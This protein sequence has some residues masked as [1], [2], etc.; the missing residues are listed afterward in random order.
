MLEGVKA[1][2]PGLL[3]NLIATRKCLIHA[4]VRA[5]GLQRKTMVGGCKKLR[6][7][8]ATRR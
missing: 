3:P 8:L 4:F 7:M 6:S 1:M 2:P 5:H